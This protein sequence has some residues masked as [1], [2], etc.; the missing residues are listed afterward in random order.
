MLF[1]HD[2]KFN[3]FNETKTKKKAFHMYIKYFNK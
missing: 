2:T 1:G 3:Y